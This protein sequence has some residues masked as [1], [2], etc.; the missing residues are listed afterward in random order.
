MKNLFA[1]KAAASL[2][3]AAMLCTSVPVTFLNQ[4]VTAADPAVIFSADLRTAK[5]LLQEEARMKLL[6]SL[7]H[8]LMAVH[9]HFA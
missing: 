5:T 1:K 7:I 6:K 3:S 9:I 2:L 8:R 4:T